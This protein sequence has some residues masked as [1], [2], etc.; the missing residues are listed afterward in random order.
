MKLLFSIIGLFIG[1]FILTLFVS[2]VSL[3]IKFVAATIKNRAA[4]GDLGYIDFIRSKLRLKKV[5]IVLILIP[6]CLS[7]AIIVP[8]SMVGPYQGKK[9]QTASKGA[10]TL[11]IRTGGFCHR[12]P[13]T[14]KQVFRTN[15]PNQI[16]EFLGL[17]SFSPSELGQC[18]CCGELSFEFYKNNEIFKAFSLHHDTH[19]RIQGQ[20]TGDIYL[21]SDS[22]KS[23][24]AWLVEK[25]IRNKLGEKQEI[26]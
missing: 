26:Q 13:E 9:F 23:L 8:S 11:V 25:G 22:I 10:D 3:H 1:L 4:E 15:D 5:L 20:S 18:E 16:N 19:I 17:L 24:N 14:E 21:T 12:N 6:F 2:F 7:I